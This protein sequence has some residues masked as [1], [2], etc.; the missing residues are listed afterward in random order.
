MAALDPTVPGESQQGPPAARL[1]GLS[2]ILRG[3]GAAALVAAASSFL[4]QHWDSG[5]DVWRYY[6]LLAH[7]GL[8]GVLGFVWGLRANDAKG[9]RTFLALAAGLVPAHFCIL[10]GLVYSR[11]SWD[12]PLT[13]VARYATW[14]APDGASALLAVGLTLAVLGA[15]TALALVA[16]ARARAGWFGGLYLVANAL[17]LVPTR[18]PSV[19]AGL[20][21]LAMTA[22]AVCELRVARREPTL[23]TLEGVFVRVMPWLPPGILLVR[24]ALHYDLSALYGAVATAAV[25]LGATALAGERR[26]APPLRA[27]LRGSALASLA[28]S[29]AFATRAADLALAL[30]ESAL[31]P[32]GGALF[33]SVATGLSLLAGREVWGVAYRR[34]AAWV[35]LASMALDLAFFPGV[36]AAVA[37]LLTSVAA[38]S[39]GFLTQRRSIFLAGGVGALLSL[40]THLRAAIDL[41]ALS[42][43]GS[44]ALVGVAVILAA[45]WVER[46]GAGFAE[47]FAAWR[48]RLAAWE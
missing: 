42:H 40:V 17:L 1:E 38:L 15:V 44:L 13:P 34:A 4:L 25:G 24:S 22:A 37:C 32:L 27:A 20:A 18:D 47:T 33:A 6:A 10:G 28:L 29:A 46:R 45:T 3:V 5:G 16:L 12:G 11:F 19:V 30:P 48:D 23:R 21:A 43:W 7:T 2:R 35:L 8:L 39:Y 31:L 41:Y 14:V 36:I 26:I 9:A